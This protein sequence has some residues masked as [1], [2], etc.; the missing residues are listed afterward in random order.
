MRISLIEVKMARS[1]RMLGHVKRDSWD[2]QPERRSHYTKNYKNTNHKLGALN[3]LHK[4][5]VRKLIFHRFRPGPVNHMG[6]FPPRNLSEHKPLNRRPFVQFQVV[7]HA[8]REWALISRERIIAQ[9]QA[10]AAGLFT[11]T[12]NNRP[13]SENEAAE[14]PGRLNKLGKYGGRSSRRKIWRGQKYGLADTIT[15]PRIKK[16]AAR[17]EWTNDLLDWMTITGVTPERLR[18]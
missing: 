5:A 17:Y 6:I 11:C 8:E 15:S 16:K 2:S 9:Q 7:G 4:T 14:K 12:L 10:V 1:E 3:V 13:A 18:A